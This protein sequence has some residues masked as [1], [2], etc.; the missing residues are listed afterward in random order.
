MTESLS[1]TL[2]NAAGKQVAEIS[3]A[4]PALRRFMLLAADGCQR[5][6]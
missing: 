1:L 6:V 4:N 2:K 3:Q 5:R